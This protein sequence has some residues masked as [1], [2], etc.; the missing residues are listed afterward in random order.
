MVSAE[1]QPLGPVAKASLSANW[2]NQPLANVLKAITDKTTIKFAYS[3]ALLKD[4]DPVTMVVNNQSLISVL[5]QLLPS[6]KLSYKV[7][8]DVIVLNRQNPSRNQKAVQNRQV[9][10]TVTDSAGV[11]IPGVSVQVKD[12]TTIGTITDSNGRYVLDVPEGATLVFSFVGYIRQEVPLNSRSVVNVTMQADQGSLE[13]VVVVGFGEQ[14]KLTVI[15]A[16]STVDV[17]EL[18]Q[19]VR[20]LTNLLAGR[21]AGIVAVQRSGEPGYDDANI[22]VRGISTFNAAGSSPLIL[23]DGVQRPMA[24]IDPEDI[25]SFSI[26]KDASATAVYGVRG[27]NGVILINTKHG[28][29]GKPQIGL[30]LNSGVSSFVR[31]PKFVDG[32]TFMEM[33]NEALTTRGKT[34]RY[35]EEAI[36]KTKTGEDPYLYPNVDWMDQIFN[37]QGNNSRVNLNINGGSENANYYVS[38]AYYTETGLM[39]TD[40]LANYNSKMKFDRYNFTS[41]LNLNA[42]KTTKLELGIQGFITN[43]NYPGRKTNDIFGAVMLASPIIFPIKYPDGRI[44]KEQSGVNNPY[45][46]LTQTG[47]STQWKNQLMSNIRVRQELDFLLPGLSATGMFSFDAY[48]EHIVNRTKTPDMWIAHRRDEKG[49]LVYE[50]TMIGSEF[51]N[52]QRTNGGNRQFYTETAINYNRTF[53]DHDVAAMLLYNQ[54]DR[55]NGFEDDF[56]LSL[57]YRSRGL[58]GR[59][60]YAYQEKYLLEFNFGYNGSENFVPARRYGFFPSIGLGWV[61]SKEPFFKPLENVFQ[62]LKFRFS[63]GIVGNSNIDPDNN[64]RFAYIGTVVGDKDTGFTFGKDYSNVYGGRD[65]GEYAVDVTW[66][67]SKKTNLGVDLWT[68]KNSLNLQVDFFKERRSGIFVRRQAVPGYAG[69]RTAPYGN[70]GITENHGIDFSMDFNK[71]LNDFDIGI[72]GTF[73]YASSK[74]IE[75]DL[76]PY[77]Y[78][79][80]DRKGLRIGKRFGYI[81]E[82]LFTSE[83]EIENSAVQSGN[84]KPG[85]IKFKDIN[86]DG[87]INLADE[88]PIGYG[89]VPEMV[90]GFGFTAGYKGFSVGAF[91]QGISNVDIL[92]NGEGFVPFQQG[93]SRGNLLSE[94][95]DRWT[96]ENPNPN[97]FYPRLAEGDETYNYR[98]ST[99]WVKNGRYLRL[100]TLELSYTVPESWFK[101]YGIKNARIYLLGYNVLT[102]SPF[103]LWDVELGDGR[104]TVYPQLKNF[105]LGLDFK[106]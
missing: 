104:G 101:R 5:D 59:S 27:A 39:K 3:D 21:L 44:A 100:K 89:S 63:H 84:E 81:A 40:E 55:I 22:W 24:N 29:V 26:L 30:G 36:Q 72:R 31:L 6:R 64:R 96:P 87:Q 12:Q 106:F 28:K 75:D 33:A 92:L 99:W 51:L 57:P 17:K 98:T 78:P 70:L 4:A 35:S 41:N 90:Y 54:S 79:W 7:M 32:I 95:T 25:E 73:T 34:P 15:G 48:N 88:M 38:A 68:L 46:E 93:V 10:G 67:E 9:T 97:A 13:E 2:Q 16:Q 8:D 74:I 71:H 53:G 65:I 66:E 82:G 103:K 42:T 69:I 80:R 85:D 49:E 62:L 91:F 77:E 83:E 47:Y 45:A 20:N 37:K 60:T 76:P 18:K 23:I 52:Y 105:S 14:K 19:P 1:G 61:A 56:I 94:I 43:G 102:L 50:Q 58:A 86:G 11:T